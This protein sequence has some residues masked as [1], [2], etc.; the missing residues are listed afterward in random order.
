MMSK[1]IYALISAVLISAASAQVVYEG[2]E[3]VGKG[4]H[5][6][7]IASDHEYR[8]EE[9]CPMLAKIMA[10]HYGFKCTVLFGVDEKGFINP[11]SRLIKGAEALKT[12]DG[13][14]IITRFFDPPEDQMQHIVDYLDTGGPLVGF[15]TSSHAFK[16]SDKNSQFK[17][18]SFNYKGE[19]F[20]GG[21]GQQYLGNSWE[22]HYGKNHRQGTRIKIIQ[23]AKDHIILRGVQDNAF[24]YA[25]G[26]QSVVRPGMQPLTNTQVLKEFKPDSEPDPKKPLVA[27]TWTFSYKG[28]DGKPNRVFHSTQGASEDFL[29][30]NYRRMS[31]NGILWTLGMESAIT[32]TNNVDF[33]GEY[34]PTIYKMKGGMKQ[35][36]PEDLAGFDSLIGDPR[37]VLDGK[38]PRLGNK[39]KTKPMKE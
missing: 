3:G 36:K 20:V 4:K 39:K 27:S 8:A 10:K 38:N 7:F 1:K 24:C 22:G 16:I 23:E 19:D 11:G 21:F 31:V 6:V 34:K 14:I 35:K 26:Y 18:Y 2:T 33:V 32:G 9:V 17:K 30:P 15:R 25:G 5:L 37:H 12:A 13:L 29:D 28:K